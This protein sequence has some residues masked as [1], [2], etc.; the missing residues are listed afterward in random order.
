MKNFIL[1]FDFFVNFYF[2]QKYLFIEGTPKTIFY[3][4]RTH[5]IFLPAINCLILLR[6]ASGLAR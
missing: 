4:A 5:F 2:E 1:F 6:K 3:V